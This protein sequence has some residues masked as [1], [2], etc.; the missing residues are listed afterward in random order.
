[1]QGRA[2]HCCTPIETKTKISK[3]EA[4]KIGEA[5][6]IA[7]LQAQGFAD[8]RPASTERNNYPVDVFQDHGAIE[9]KTGLVSNGATAQH[10]R[11][12]I[13]QP[14]KAETE[15]LKTA[16]HEEKHAWNEQKAQAI[17]DRKNQALKDLSKQVGGKIKGYTMTTIINPDKKTV[18]VFRFDGF[19][20]RIPWNSPA[21]D[22]AYV[23]TFKYKR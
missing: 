3:S 4:G 23:G 17:L 8:A 21:V 16:S 7:Q 11:A 20:L 2:Y 1:M 18:D 5:V 10:W 15:W 22:K 19:H 12:T 14:G 13:G 6:I 9:V